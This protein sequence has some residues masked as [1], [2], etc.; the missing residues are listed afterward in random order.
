MV[1]SQRTLKFSAMSALT[2]ISGC[3]SGLV[4]TERR[5]GVLG[6][7][8]SEFWRS[9]SRWLWNYSR[10]LTRGRGAVSWDGLLTARSMGEC[11]VASAA[12]QSFGE[13]YCRR[14]ARLR[15]FRLTT[16]SVRLSRLVWWWGDRTLAMV[17]RADWTRIA[18]KRR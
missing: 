3:L 11:N 9:A 18:K 4:S 2:G 14:G 8:G 6:Y 17:T 5:Y 13:V 16:L 12:A 1:F 10:V 15:T 7:A